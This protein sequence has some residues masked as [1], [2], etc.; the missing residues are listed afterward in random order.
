MDC[1]ERTFTVSGRAIHARLCGDARNGPTFVLVYGTGVT[2]AFWGWLQPCLGARGLVLSYDRTGSPG[3][4][5]KSNISTI[6]SDLLDLLGKASLP[7]PYWLVG[8]SSG[9]L[10]V[11]YFA[12]LHP[13]ETAGIIL[14]DPTPIKTPSWLGASLRLSAVMTRWIA[15]LGDLGLLRVFNPFVLKIKTLPPAD[16][17]E[18]ARA[19][20]S[21]PHLRA[22]AAEMAAVPDFADVVK[23]HP[24]DPAL[25]VLVATAGAWDTPKV[26]RELE[27]RGR[28]QKLSFQ[29]AIVADHERIAAASAHGRHVIIDGSDH[30]T[31]VADKTFATR[32]CDEIASW[33][34][35]GRPSAG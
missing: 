25:P 13:K 12:A 30:V 10:I 28:P 21:G 16:D 19:L 33:T 35:S 17:S 11:Q 27:R 31:I 7:G 24:V 22:T 1:W 29:A 26:R 32:L 9:A 2:S 23:A 5:E 8:H 15:T 6:T 34:S 14:I 3:E 18:I 4:V 20:A